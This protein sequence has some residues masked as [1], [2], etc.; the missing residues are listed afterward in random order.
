MELYLSRP[1]RL[2]ITRPCST[3]S[4][5]PCVTSFAAVATCSS[6]TWPFASRS[7]CS[8]EPVIAWYRRMWRCWWRWKSRPQPSGR[9][10]IPFE[11]IELI[12]RISRE[13][14]TWGAPRI[15]G[16]LLKLGYDLSEATVARYMIKH[17]G[18]SPEEHGDRGEGDRR[19]VAMA[20]WVL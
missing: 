11:T 2:P 1:H 6:R 9:P 15:H 12:R 14:P 3:S 10:R 18:R 4:L 20:E 7:S 8:N 5:P 16:E 19:A 17:R 13:N